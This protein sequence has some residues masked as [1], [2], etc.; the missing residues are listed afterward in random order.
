LT[1]FGLMV[2][3]N[4]ADRYLECALSHLQAHVDEIVVFDDRSDDATVAVC[5]EYSASVGV[6]PD[7]VAPMLVHEGRFRRAAWRWLE[8]AARPELGDWVFAVD[9]DEIVAGNVRSAAAD[10]AAAASRGA[11]VAIPEVFA[12][13]PL[14]VRRDR[15]WAG[16]RALRLFEW[17]PDA[18]FPY[19]DAEERAAA[20][21]A[22][23]PLERRSHALG[24]GQAPLYATVDPFPADPAQ[25]QLL[26]L[27]YADLGDRVVRY[28]RYIGRRGHNPLHVQ[29]ILAAAAL[30]P[31]DGP[32]VDVWRGVRP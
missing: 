28:R 3:R 22:L 19:E 23:P 20:R 15:M 11:T 26:H 8:Q 31:W 9:A 2:T 27:G 5:G 13:D 16:Q 18:R 6:R 21:G 7:D 1:V 4:E 30:T 25:L 32:A 24:A 17:L 12:I 29:S 10:A 14:A